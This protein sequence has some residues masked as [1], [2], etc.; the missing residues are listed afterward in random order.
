MNGNEN[1]NGLIPSL[2]RLLFSFVGRFGKWML[3][4]SQLMIKFVRIA[5]NINIIN[6][7]FN[8]LCHRC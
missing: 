5:K 7:L 3:G 8:R 6:L 4:N 1:I 2:I